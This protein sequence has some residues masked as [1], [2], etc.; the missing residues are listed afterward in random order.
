MPKSEPVG[1]VFPTEFPLRVFGRLGEE[2]EPFVMEIVRQHVADEDILTVTS[3]P[4]SG[5]A[6]LAVTVTFTARSRDQLD[7][8]YRTLSSDQ[9]VLMLL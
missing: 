3:R 4:S 7:A 8:L 5:N 9:R 6:Y 2:F 1:F